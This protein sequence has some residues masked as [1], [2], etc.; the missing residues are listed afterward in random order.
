[1]TTLT[2]GKHQSLQRYKRSEQLSLD[3]VL[4]EGDQVVEADPGRKKVKR[5]TKSDGTD[6]TIVPLY[7][8]TFVPPKR[9]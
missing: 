6:P 7:S 3:L 4:A 5:L 1:M 8:T 9:W 2:R